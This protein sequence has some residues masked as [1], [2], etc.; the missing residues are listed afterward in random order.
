VSGISRPPFNWSRRSVVSRG[1]RPARPSRSFPGCLA[2]DFAHGLWGRS[3]ATLGASCSGFVRAGARAALAEFFVSA[4]GGRGVLFFLV[5]RPGRPGRACLSVSVAPSR[6]QR[7]LPVPSSP[8][9]ASCLPSL[10]LAIGWGGRARGV[11]LF[12]AWLDP[13]LRPLSARS[14]ACAASPSRF[15][16]CPSRAGVRGRAQSAAPVRL[17][18]GAPSRVALGFIRGRVRWR[19]SPLYH[20][21]GSAVR[22]RSCVGFGLALS[23][24]SRCSRSRSRRAARCGAAAAHGRWCCL[25]FARAAPFAPV[26]GRDG[27]FSSRRTRPFTRL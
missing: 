9:S 24:W 26:M 23:A 5:S 13:A 3:H 7:R 25:L 22:R 27:A 2:A 4:S 8:A 1:S 20:R 6:W 10:P 11:R 21:P 14:G 17:Y 16:R 12:P 15:R 19:A 18:W